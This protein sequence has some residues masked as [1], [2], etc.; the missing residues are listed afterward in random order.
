MGSRKYRENLGRPALALEGFQLWVHGREFPDSQEYYDGNWL[1]VTA[2]CGAAGASVWVS[3]AILMTTNL[4]GWAEECRQLH[5][6]TVQEA[7][8]KSYERNLFV[9]IRTADRHGHLTMHVEITPEPLQQEHRFEFAIDQTY[10]PLII[11]QCRAILE[12]YPVRSPT[13][14]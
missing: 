11:S 10:L 6:G 12:E 4:A 8:L 1:N 9:T 3:G 13:A 2:H 14:R 7:A 5:A